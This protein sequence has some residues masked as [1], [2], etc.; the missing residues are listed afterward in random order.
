M[1]ELGGCGVKAGLMN[2]GH[3]TEASDCRTEAWVGGA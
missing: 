3:R 2:P 1:V